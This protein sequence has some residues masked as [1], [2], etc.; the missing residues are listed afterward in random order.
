[1]ICTPTQYR[2]DDKIEKNEMGR[3]CSSDGEGKRRVEG[4]GGET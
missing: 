3:V 4:F 2:A 1:M